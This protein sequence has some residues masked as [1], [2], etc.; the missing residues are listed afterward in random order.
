MKPERRQVCLSIT[1]Q[2]EGGEEEAGPHFSMVPTD[3]PEGEA[4]G[5]NN[6]WKFSRLPPP[7]IPA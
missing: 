2:W 4:E 3:R 7:P 1:S 6:S 5:A